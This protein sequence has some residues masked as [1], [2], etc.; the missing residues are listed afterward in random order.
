MTFAKRTLFLLVVAVFMMSS[1]ALAALT[2]PAELEAEFTQ[3]P[4]ST[5]VN[6]VDAGTIVQVI[7]DCG[8]DTLDEVYDYYKEKATGNGWTVQMEDQS[9]D[10]YVMLMKKGT[11]GG[12]VTVAVEDGKTSA[13]VSIMKQ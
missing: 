4:G 5:I 3:Y 8:D 9:V 7:I 6:V 12:N 13:T 2:M 1:M 11:N 10:I